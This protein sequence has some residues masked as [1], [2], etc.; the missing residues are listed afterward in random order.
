ML[1]GTTLGSRTRQ[2]NTAIVTTIMM[3]DRKITDN[4]DQ[5]EKERR[6][7][8]VIQL[9]W[10]KYQVRKQKEMIAQI[11]R[12]E[13]GEQQA[14]D[15]FK[16]TEPKSCFIFPE[17]NSLREVFKN[18]NE[19]GYFQFFIIVA[20]IISS[21][22]LAFEHPEDDPEATKADVL[23]VLDV[24]FTLLFIFEMTSKMI[25][26]GVCMAEASY[27]RDPWNQMDFCI[28]IVSAIGLLPFANDIKV[29]R[30]ARTFRVLRPLR[31]LRKF[32][33]LAALTATLVNSLVPLGIVAVICFFVISIFAVLWIALQKGRVFRCSVD[34]DM[35]DHKH[36]FTYVECLAEGG[37]W[38][39]A[40]QSYDNYFR[41]LLTLFEVMTLEDWQGVMYNSIDTTDI[42]AL[43]AAGNWHEESY[44]RQYRGTWWWGIMFL[45]FVMVGAFFFLNLI[46]GVV[47]NAF[48]LNEKMDA[49][50]LDREEALVRRQTWLI[51]MA[52]PIHA[53]G[54]Y[55]KVRKPVCA[56]ITSVCWDM[57]MAAAIVG[58]VF[59]MAFEHSEQPES[60]TNFFYGVNVFFSL[61]FTFEL[62]L[63]VIAY[64]PVRTFI[65]RWN[66]FDGVIVLVSLIELAIDALGT[67]NFPINPTVL[68]AFRVFRLTRLLKL[69]PHSEG[70]QA[71][72]HTFL[73]ALPV[74]TNVGLLLF[75]VFFIYAVLAVQIFSV[76]AS[77]GAVK[78]P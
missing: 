59:C 26:D 77:P 21:I 75:M 25:A 7:G 48:D 34:E 14:K 60:L 66:V 62:M 22:T 3:M 71:V 8:L 70:L 30:V 16:Q 31:A 15:D 57:F 76:R 49:T 5:A 24:L 39:V 46:V 52:S 74:L 38:V 58:N 50:G 2:D 61:L 18:L 69:V 1:Q 9:W 44:E 13:E 78:R 43:D 35:D 45:V 37:E 41:S 12:E 63:K 40:Q 54:W 53:G 10:A 23:F 36:Y 47:V 6:A 11:V 17:D 51:T 65:D 56:L 20:I 28:V 27:L 68:R 72:F 32:P 4:M 33:Q 29:L 19:D 64:N 42:K 73:E 67:V 55:L